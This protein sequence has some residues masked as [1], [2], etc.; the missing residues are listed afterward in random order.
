MRR[1]WEKQAPGQP[2]AGDQEDGAEDLAQAVKA[3]TPLGF[4]LRLL[5]SVLDV[6]VDPSIGELFCELFGPLERFSAVGED[7]G[8][9]VLV[10]DGPLLV[11]VLIGVDAVSVDSYSSEVVADASDCTR[12]FMSTVR[13]RCY[14]CAPRGKGE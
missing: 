2:A 1:L 9:P 8:S 12:R 3:G 13:Y 14:G 6:D 5:R 4:G 11:R 7:G 10:F